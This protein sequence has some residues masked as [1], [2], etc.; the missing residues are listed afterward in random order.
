[1]KKPVMNAPAHL[2][3][4]MPHLQYNIVINY[5]PGKDIPLA[6]ALSRKP[7]SQRDGNLQECIEMQVHTAMINLPVSDTKLKRIQTATQE[8]DTLCLLR[9]A[10]L[11]G[12]PV[13]KHMCS[14]AIQP[15]W[16]F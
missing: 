10:I 11:N 6:D 9:T 5:K 3:R 14:A 16:N 13:A 8:D 4:M 2:Q 12:W 7:L 15:Y 1:M